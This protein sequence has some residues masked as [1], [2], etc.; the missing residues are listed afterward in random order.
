MALTHVCL[1]LNMLGA[2][3]MQECCVKCIYLYMTWMNLIV[4]YHRGC[5]SEARAESLSGKTQEESRHKTN[6]SRFC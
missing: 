5:P 6:T 4:S 2:V 3:I 1:V